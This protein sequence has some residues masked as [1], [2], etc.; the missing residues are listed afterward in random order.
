[1]ARN[2]L[3]ALSGLFTIRLRR[4][5][6]SGAS[7]KHVA[8]T[9][10]EVKN[11]R[12]PVRGAR[13]ISVP[14]LGK[15]LSS[16]T[17]RSQLRKSRPQSLVSTVIFRL[18][19]SGYQNESWQ[20]TLAVRFESGLDIPCDHALVAGEIHYAVVVPQDRAWAGFDDCD[21]AHRTVLIAAFA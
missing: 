2:C 6:N 3:Y 10:S 4:A 20:T 12:K 19:I 15:P 16:A 1:V 13:A 17:R 5:A 18:A 9:L 7:L 8:R 14:T 21:H 11:A